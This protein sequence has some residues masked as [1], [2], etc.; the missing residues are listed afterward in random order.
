MLWLLC[1]DQGNDL[2]TG[3][4]LSAFCC[5]PR[6]RTRGICQDNISRASQLITGR[7]CQASSVSSQVS[8]PS[9]LQ[10]VHPWQFQ[11]VV[12]AES[13]GPRYPQ[14][15]MTGKNTRLPS[16]TL[17]STWVRSVFIWCVFLLL[18]TQ[19][20][21]EADSAPWSLSHHANY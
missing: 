1:N 5:F 4:H 10:P 19:V 6:Q 15:L 14:S 21:C 3:S 12:R 7:P 8:R 11:D 20:S 13:A 18:R 16:K 9:S 2:C 17:T